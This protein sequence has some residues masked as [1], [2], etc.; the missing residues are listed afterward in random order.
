MKK[1]LLSLLLA[2]SATG[3]VH[4]QSFPDKPVKIVLSVGVGSGPDVMARKVAEVLTEKW[5]Q[6]V[7]VENKP[8]GA[9]VIG[10]NYIN[11]EPANG[12]TLGFLDGGT[13]VSYAVL[14]KNNEPIRQL[15]PIVP[16]LDANMAL[17]ASSQFASYADLKQQ[18][19]KN[20]SY[21]SWNIGS[22]AHVLGAEYL[23]TLD[24]KGTHIPYKDFGQWQAD[25]ASQQ[26]PFAFGSTGTIKNLV[27]AG[28]N[29]IF[30]IAAAQ[31]DPRYPSIPTVKELTGR[32]ITTL[33]AWCGF[34]VPVNAPSHIKAKLE[35][36][37]RQAIT[38]RR[39][40]ETMLRFDY[41]SLHQQ[42]LDDF[43]KKIKHDQDLYTDMIA[44]YK[45]ETQ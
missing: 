33:I 15:E 11:N 44:K 3:M 23:S 37:I 32:N 18:I 39:V 4:A 19:S 24:L 26:V 5:N 9:G 7:V 42:S 31:R 27:Q 43:K 35:K 36:D 8:G 28:K 25:V 6:P 10:L 20:P 34:Y 38:D 13:V 2:V 45:I 14:Y 29:Q 12:Y 30:A 41:I 16:V 1:I 17:F 21:S 22:V 40:Q